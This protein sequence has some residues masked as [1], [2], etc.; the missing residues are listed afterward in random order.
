M[1]ESNASDLNDCNMIENG[2]IVGND[3][4]EAFPFLSLLCSLLLY[5]LQKN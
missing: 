1:N 3:G 5:F 2:E 4:N